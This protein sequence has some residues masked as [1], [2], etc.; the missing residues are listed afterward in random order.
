MQDLH[1]ITWDFS[2]QSMD[3]SIADLGLSCSEAGGIL[4]PRPGIEP[5]SPALQ[6]GFLTTGPPGKSP[7]FTL[8]KIN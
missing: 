7:K 6:G 3:S 5:L 8:N 1:R 4:V 2:L